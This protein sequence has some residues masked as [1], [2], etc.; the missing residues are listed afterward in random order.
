MIF[1]LIDFKFLSLPLGRLFYIAMKWFSIACLI[2]FAELPVFAQLLTNGFG[3][4]ITENQYFSKSFVKS[5]GIKSVTVFVDTKKKNS[6]IHN[7]HRGMI[8]HF[9]KSGNLILIKNFTGKPTEENITSMKSFQ[10]EDS[11]LVAYKSSD[12][13]GLFS[14]EYEFLNGKIQKLTT[15]KLLKKGL[16]FDTPFEEM[17]V[18]AVDSFSYVEYGT[19]L[20]AIVH[21]RYKIPYRE[22]LNYFNE[23]G[24]LVEVVDKLTRTNT[25]NK[26]SMYFNSQNLLDSL[27]I[28]ENQV[29]TKKEAIHYEY[30]LSI[31][32]NE[33]VLKAKKIYLNDVYQREYQFLYDNEGL[34]TYVLQRE[35]L[36]DLITI[37]KFT[38][39]QY[40]SD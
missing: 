1:R 39:Y 16:S 4:Q 31:R 12:Q 6:V 15:R 27:V 35:T 33:D 29:G 5:N 7:A 37:F 24:Q 9:D 36:N 13:Y 21:N 2:L 23:A 28:H 26:K 14:E 25:K 38:D 34:T 10:Y 22:I 20:K 8:Y 19:Q 11:L 18:I 30:D 40:Y 17:R 32:N 3:D